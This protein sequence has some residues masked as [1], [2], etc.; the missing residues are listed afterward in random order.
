M[1]LVGGERTIQKLDHRA[2]TWILHSFLPVYG[3][4]VFFT[5]SGTLDEPLYC[6]L[7]SIVDSLWGSTK[8]LLSLHGEK[9]QLRKWSC[10]W[11]NKVL[12]KLAIFAEDSELFCVLWCWVLHWRWLTLEASWEFFFSFVLL[13]LSTVPCLDSHLS[14]YASTFNKGAIHPAQAAYHSRVQRMGLFLF[15]HQNILIKHCQ[16]LRV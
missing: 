6:L 3:F 15:R 8:F 4:T 5:F 2:V 9:I 1:L 10:S 7:S 12:C 16:I 11:L 14:S 13:C